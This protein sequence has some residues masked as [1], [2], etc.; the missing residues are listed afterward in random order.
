MTMQDNNLENARV[1]YQVAVNLWTYEGET[2]WSKFNAMLVANGIFLAAISLFMT[3]SNRPVFS[4][5]LPCV[6]SSV[7]IILCVFWFLLTKR[8]FEYHDYWVFSAREIERQYFK[9]LIQTVSRGERFADGQEVQFVG[10]KKALKMSNLSW[11][12]PAKCAAYVIIGLFIFLYLTI[13]IINATRLMGYF[14][15]V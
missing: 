4:I 3:A 7:G 13:L 11:L 15:V 12:V 1:G 8:G 2:L 14:Y 9:S 5:L 6:M 10:E